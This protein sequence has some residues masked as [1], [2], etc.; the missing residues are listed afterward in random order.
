MQLGALVVNPTCG[1]HSVHLVDIVSCGTGVRLRGCE[2]NILF[3]RLPSGHVFLD[4]LDHT[5]YAKRSTL[6]S[7]GSPR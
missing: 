2:T 5:K 3:G 6:Q 1:A 4:S 7:V